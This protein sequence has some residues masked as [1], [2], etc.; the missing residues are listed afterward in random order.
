MRQFFINFVLISGAV[1]SGAW[2][3]WLLVVS[4]HLIWGAVMLAIACGAVVLLGSG[5]A[6]AAETK[7]LPY[8][9]ICS[10]EVPRPLG[11]VSCRAQVPA[12]LACEVAHAAGKPW[13][14][15][16]A[17]RC[18]DTALRFSDPRVGMNISDAEFAAMVR[19]AAS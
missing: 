18:V 2:G 5:A 15:A 3:V 16:R 4:R 17:A 14:S 6:H 7:L 9:E 12:M 10:Q 1:S 8:V 11:C 13:D 19:C